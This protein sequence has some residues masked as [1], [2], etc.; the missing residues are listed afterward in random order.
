M[1]KM[2]IAAITAAMLSGGAGVALA[3]HTDD[4]PD[5]EPQ[6]RGLCTAF[7]NGN[8]NGWE[9]NGTPPPFQDL[10]DRADDGDPDTTDDVATYCD[11][12]IGGNPGPNGNSEG[13]GQGGN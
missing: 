13:K 8:K 3:G 7:H 2:I 4:R 1:R 11:G 12:L 5:H 6:D 9:K 10:M